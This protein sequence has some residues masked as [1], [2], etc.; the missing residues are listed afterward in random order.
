MTPLKNT[1]GKNNRKFADGI[2]GDTANVQFHDINQL[3][4]RR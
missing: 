2:F 4:V 1:A 3:H